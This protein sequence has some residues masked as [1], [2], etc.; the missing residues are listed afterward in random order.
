MIRLL[1]CR[2]SAMGDVI[3]LLPVLKGV[4][5][6]NKNIEIYLLT[7][8]T[9]FPVFQNIDRLHLI[10][11]DL[12][13][14]HKGIAGL[15]RLY[16][17]IKVDVNPDMVIDVHQV[18]RTHILN[19]FFKASGCRIVTFDKGKKEKNKLIKTKVLNQLPTTTERYSGAFV[20]AG[21][22]LR[23]PD[24]PVF[25]NS[26]PPEG[27][28]RIFRNGDTQPLL[29]G[30]APFA[31]HAQKVWGMERIEKLTGLVA[32]RYDATVILFGGGENEIKQLNQIADRQEHCVV[33][34][35]HFNLTQEIRL[36]PMLKI[37][38]SMDSANM[39]LASMAGVP[40]ISI[41][42][43]THP[44]LGFAPYKQAAENMIQYDGDELPCRPCS[45]YGNKKC[46][47]ND[48]RCMEYISVDAV[49]KRIDQIISEL[50]Q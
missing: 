39:H 25:P 47:Y 45:V 16:K 35:N 50:Y 32:R 36:L 24:L 26:F 41:W 27:I 5:D 42:G 20:K 49:M 31:R 40:T 37:M 43:A 17:E 30:I 19:L 6:V 22:K 34:A 11:A 48:I 29:I 13:A 33:S 28:E 8:Q 10:S 23:M 46:I 14:R 18:I 1:V 44:A 12:K 15:F 3:L 21:F 2:L 38:I 9:F 4:L 7:R